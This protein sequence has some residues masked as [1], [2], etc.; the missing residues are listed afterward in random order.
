MGQDF[1]AHVVHGDGV[2]G[3]ACAGKPGGNCVEEKRV[4]SVAQDAHTESAANEERAEPEEDAPECPRKD[5]AGV[6]GLSGGHAQVLRTGHHVRGADQA[7]E[8]TLEP[9]QAPEV[10]VLEHDGGVFPVREAKGVVV[11]VPAYHGDEGE[12]HEPHG[13]EHLADAE[14]ELGLAVP[15]HGGDVDQEV[16]GQLDRK[17]D[18]RR[19][20]VCPEV[21]QRVEQGQLERDQGALQNPE[22]PARHH[23]KRLVDKALGKDAE[24]SPLDREVAHHFCAAAGDLKNR[25]AP[26]HEPQE[27]RETPARLQRRADVHKQRH[28]D[29]APDGNKLDLPPLQLPVRAALLVLPVLGSGRRRRV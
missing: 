13:E 3:R 22:V 29:R 8:K 15:L 11:R 19:V 12:E 7:R 10:V 9:A 16:D 27:E 5:F 2:W 14:P 23:A 21:D 18:C 6:N 4:L 25:D 28:P 20:A 17:R 26:D 1:D 24:R